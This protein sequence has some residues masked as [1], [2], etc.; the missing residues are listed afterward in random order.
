MFLLL[1]SCAR[2]PVDSWLQQ[3]NTAMAGRT[4][5]HSEIDRVEYEAGFTDGASMVHEALKVGERPFRPVLQA[6]AS[7][8]RFREVAPESTQVGGFTFSPE[9]VQTEALM[10]VSEVDTETGL[11]LFSVSEV[12]S[13]AFGRGQAD[14][15]TWALSAIGQSLVHPV[16]PLVLP[17]AWEPFTKPRDGQ[18][19]DADKKSVRILW[20][21]GHL[22]W[23]WKERGF[24]SHR[25]WRIWNE[26]E[27]PRWIGLTEQ[28]IWV[29][30]MAGQAIA[31]DLVSGGILKT[32]PAV[33]HLTTKANDLET[34]EQKVLKEFNSAEF[35]RELADLRKVADS[36]AI[37]DLMAV[38]ELLRGMG[39]QADREAF[40]WY[41]K[42][43][44]KGSP[45]AMLQVGTLL[46]HG[47]SI[48]ADK[49]A[50]KTWLDRAVQAG[51]PD[52]SAVIKM[53]WQNSE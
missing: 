8:P 21:P 47:K 29:E 40:T 1:F 2:R 46:F 28:A 18:D 52:A 13:S 37:P 39:E 41:L 22:A 30:S 19:L 36:G 45:E 10:P 38:A 43:A 3:V 32:Q 9:D 4:A 11:L 35:Q 24:P 33:M 53:L 20:A 44:E 17:T 23:A 5:S 15:F 12:K 26:A 51:Q 42:A 16:P 27:A 7:A 25:T 6:H 48:P 49:V 34:Y 14:G 50:A 31:L